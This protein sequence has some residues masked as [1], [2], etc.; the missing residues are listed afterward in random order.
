M[1]R[2]TLDLPMSMSHEEARPSS[3]TEALRRKKKFFDFLDSLDKDDEPQEPL[4]SH[5]AMLSLTMPSEPGSTPPSATRSEKRSSA[6]PLSSKASGRDLT[7]NRPKTAPELRVNDTF[8]RMR[9]TFVTDLREDRGCRSSP[10]STKAKQEV[11]MTKP[12]ATGKRKRPDAVTRVSEARQVFKDF[13]F[14]MTCT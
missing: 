4:N 13:S 2:R 10:A 9:E 3:E 14:C 1:H 7:G 8:E 12:Q 6:A 11:I 5:Q